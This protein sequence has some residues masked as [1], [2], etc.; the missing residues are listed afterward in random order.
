MEQKSLE[1]IIKL[2]SKNSISVYFSQFIA[3]LTDFLFRTDDGPLGGV[4]KF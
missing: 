4:E 1:S 3:L 2:M